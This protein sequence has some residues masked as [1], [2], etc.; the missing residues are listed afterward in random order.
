MSANGSTDEV[1]QDHY[2]RLQKTLLT[3]VDKELDEMNSMIRETTEDLK[4]TE[5]DKTA[6]G[7]ALYQ[8]NSK[9]GRMNSQLES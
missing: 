9:I 3:A 1:L 7:V 8:A 6:I 4:R 5:D 2:T